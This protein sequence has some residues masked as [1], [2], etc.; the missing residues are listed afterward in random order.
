MAIA[1]LKKLD[2]V[3]KNVQRESKMPKYMDDV[4]GKHPIYR[5]PPKS[6]EELDFRTREIKSRPAGGRN[7]GDYADIAKTDTAAMSDSWSRVDKEDGKY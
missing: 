1:D 3:I 4:N 7:L 6:R 2:T 5:E